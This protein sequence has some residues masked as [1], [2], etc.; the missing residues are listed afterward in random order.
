[1]PLILNDFEKYTDYPIGLCSGYP[2]GSEKEDQLARILNQAIDAGN[3]EA[4]IS[5]KY[6]YAEMVDYGLLEELEPY[7][8]KLT[9]K[10]LG[11]I[12]AHQS[13]R[14]N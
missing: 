8:Y 14:N 2:Q 5:T 6:K 4:G 3:L 11:M 12:Y 1:M 9:I 10:S 7:K 13:G